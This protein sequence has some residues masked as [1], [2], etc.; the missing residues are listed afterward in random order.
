MLIMVLLAHEQRL[1]TKDELVRI[2]AAV[3]WFSLLQATCRSK[4]RI[5]WQGRQNLMDFYARWDGEAV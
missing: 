2:N 3:G 5:R 1:F 4:S